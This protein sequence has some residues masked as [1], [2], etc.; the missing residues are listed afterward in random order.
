MKRKNDIQYLNYEG[1]E[2]FILQA[3][4]QIFGR[5]GYNHLPPG[6]LLQMF[7]DQLKKITK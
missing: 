7:V 4:I 5:T 1:F 6:R 2:D 3:A